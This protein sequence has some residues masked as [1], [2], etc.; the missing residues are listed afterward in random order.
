MTYMLC[1]RCG[2]SAEQHDR[3]L[4]NV[5]YMEI[6]ELERTK[7]GYRMRL[8][9]CMETEWPKKYQAAV[10]DLEFGLDYLTVTSQTGYVSPNPKE[11]HRLYEARPQYHMPVHVYIVYGPGVSMIAVGE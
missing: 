1:Q 10:A 5:P 6:P 4:V 3:N 2:Y 9:T 7:R 11:E 8:L